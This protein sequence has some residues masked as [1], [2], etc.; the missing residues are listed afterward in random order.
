[1][2]KWTSSQYQQ[3]SSGSLLLLVVQ[4]AT[5]KHRAVTR[6]LN[7]KQ[8]IATYEKDVAAIS[9]SGVAKDETI[10]ELKKH[11]EYLQKLGQGS[12]EL[13]KLAGVQEKLITSID[14]QTRAITALL[15]GKAK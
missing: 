4:P 12:P 6:L 11:V 10:V 13:K 3:L 14:N 1:M 5:S 2:I 9:Q 15:Q 8:P 7:T